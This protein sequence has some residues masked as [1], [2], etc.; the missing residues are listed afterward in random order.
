M[1]EE[2]VCPVCGVKYLDNSPYFSFKNK[3][4]NNDFLAVK[5]CQ[6][7]KKEGCINPNYNSNNKYPD[8]LNLIEN[9]N[10]N[11]TF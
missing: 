5:V 1:K 3:K 8:Y 7:A 9:D 2:N 10:R 11:Q 4:T 6:Y